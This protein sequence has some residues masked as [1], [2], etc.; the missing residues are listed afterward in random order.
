[1]EDHLQAV[2]W[3]SVEMHSVQVEVT[4]DLVQV[5]E[6]EFEPFNQSGQEVQG[7]QEVGEVHV[8]TPEVHL[9]KVQ[10]EV[11]SQTT[12]QALR[13]SLGHH[14]WPKRRQVR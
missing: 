3:A 13:R 9:Q 7:A 2:H 10:R 5:L 1:M 14:L 11:H 6:Q 4:V 12:P 8:E